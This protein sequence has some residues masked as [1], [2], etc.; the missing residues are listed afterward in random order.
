MAAQ[1]R[2][3][4][5][6]DLEL[7]RALNLTLTHRTGE[8]AELLGV[9]H[10]TY[11]YRVKAALR[12]GMKPGHLSDTP[13]GAKER[14][15]MADKIRTL[16]ATIKSLHRE[17]FT[18]AAI[19]KHIIG[20][21]DEP[22]AP[23]KWLVTPPKYSGVLGVPTLFASDWHW[24][25]MVAPAEI[26]FANEYDIP[27]AHKRARKLVN[28]TMD[29]LFNRLRDP[30][31]PGVVFALGGDMLS[32][33]I[34]EELV[35]TNEQPIMP[36]IV[37]LLGVLVW[38][39]DTLLSRFP[40]IFLPCVTGNHGRTT[41][42]PVA[43]ERATTNY[44][45]LIYQLLALHYQNDKRVQFHI[46]DGSDAL[47]RVYDHRFLLTHGDQFRGG[48]GVTGALMPIMRGRHKKASRDSSIGAPWDTIIMGHWH[49]LMQLPHLIV[50]GSL[51]GLDEYA[52][53]CNFGFERAAQ[54]LWINHP[55]H[56]IAYQ[57][58]VYVD[59]GKARTP[60]NNWV[61]WPGRGAA[62]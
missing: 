26:A 35:I 42:K 29:L 48:D 31:Y 23:P 21:R 19:R 5:A 2:N 52:Y 18:R 56:G 62:A 57:M 6:T 27:I 40:A 8:A 3:S 1:P 12:K 61:S 30:N 10:Q 58:P 38:C 14:A 59:E 9:P 55:Q 41:R 49:Q 15:E 60:A 36:T 24:G 11:S 37:D 46:P 34:H 4:P 53:Q 43:K 28:T 39:V 47:Y 32:G 7:Q 51:K 45:W 54:A 16:E 20:V 25:E 13:E 44:D 33:T 17:E 50:N 22:I